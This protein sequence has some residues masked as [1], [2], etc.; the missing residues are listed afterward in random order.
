MFNNVSWQGYW[1]VLALIAAGYYLVIYLLYFRNDFKVSAWK[2]SA[3]MAS[4]TELLFHQSDEGLYP[5]SE[6]ENIDRLAESCMD[7]INA[8]FDQ[9]KQTKCV[10]QEL[11]YALQQLLRKYAS[12]KDSDYRSIVSSVI[13]THASHYCGIHLGEEEVDHVWL[14]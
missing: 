6:A 2:R 9:S 13:A 4:P 7:E 10:K 11:I 12:L 3:G 1:T 5:A 14:G 8:Y